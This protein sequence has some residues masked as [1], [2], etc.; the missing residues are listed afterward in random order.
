MLKTWDIFDTLIARRCIFPHLIFKMMEDAI[1]IQGFVQARIAAENNVAMRGVNYNLDDIYAEFLSISG[2]NEE[3]CNILK[4]IEC[5]LEIEQAI[6]IT[7]NILKVKADDILI[8]DM[9][10]P[11]ETIRAMLEKCGLIVPVEVVITSRGKHS[12]QIWRQL[13]AQN[14]FVFH[15]GDNEFSDVKNP[16]EVGLESGLTFLSPLHWVEDYFLKKDFDFAAYLREIRLKNPYQEDIKR[17]YWQACTFDMAIL[18]ILVQ[19]IDELQKKCGFEYLGFCGRDTYYLW[20]LYKKFKQDKNEIPAPSD[21]LYY[22]RKL[23]YA[24]KNE[25][26]EYYSSRIK[27]RKALLLDLCGTASHLNI[28]REDCNLDYSILMCYLINP[29]YA[30]SHYTDSR[31]PKKFFSIKEVFNEDFSNTDGDFY[32]S[33][34]TKWFAPIETLNRPKHTTP[35]RLY[36]L[37]IGEKIIPKVIFTE[38]N[39]TEY[40][41]VLES[42]TKLILSS[43]INWGGA[44]NLESALKNLLDLIN[45]FSE[46]FQMLDFS[47]EQ[48]LD[49]IIENKYLFKPQE[50]KP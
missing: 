50:K 16:R 10:L 9:Y 20:L 24:S 4:N 12:G 19:L 29:L 13:A 41:D 28:L 25:L 47:F 2:L 34:A 7:E 5:Q 6:P 15:I 33:Y 43:K 21:Y 36:N 48:K 45:I 26:A 1:K 18:I 44:N 23:I 42:C 8:S 17:I 37:K 46:H 30:E 14:E 31:V 40:F 35:I 27:N 32:F 22:S 38:L 11:E 49:A 39:D 3:S